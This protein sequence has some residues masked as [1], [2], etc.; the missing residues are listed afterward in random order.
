MTL[1]SSGA[2]ATNPMG[3]AAAAT[4]VTDKIENLITTVT[5][6]VEGFMDALGSAGDQP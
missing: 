4:G 5:A 3:G 6:E 1:P 2:P